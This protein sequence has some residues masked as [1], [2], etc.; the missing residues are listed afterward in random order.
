MERPRA[1]TSRSRKPPNQPVE[2]DLH[3]WIDGLP[4]GPPP[5]TPYWHDGVL[6]AG[7]AEI[8]ASYDD[9]ELEVAGAT[10]LVGGYEGGRRSGPAEWLYLRGDGLEPLP[11][12]ARQWPSL[13]AD[14]RIAYWSTSPSPG[15]TAFVTW[16]TETN[17]ELA[18]RTLRGD[19]DM[20]ARRDLLG[21]DAA[22]IGYLLNGSSDP[23]KAPDAE[24][25]RW[26]VRTDTIEATDLT[27]DPSLALGQF[28]VFVGLED[29]YTSPDGTRELFTGPAPGDPSSD[30]CTN[31]LR[32]RPAGPLDAVNPDDIVTL[33]LP[34][35]IPAMRLWNAWS[36]RGTWG[37]WWE[38]DDTVLLD[39][40][41]DKHSYLVRCSA[42]GGTCELVFDLG[43]NSSRTRHVHAGLGEELGLR[44]LSPDLVT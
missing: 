29:A 28:D 4:D 27:Y 43:A 19:D 21:I 15:T 1:G 14:G 32:V 31:T 24:I 33:P 9:V 36:D 18:S 13:S 26:D 39:A 20:C 22:G 34:T 40:I 5:G 12:P 42:T 25:V 35:G 30:C 8:D 38:S 17:T 3:A 10:V 11:V 16:D 44:P 7:G 6:H 2:S 41:V 23:R 37:V